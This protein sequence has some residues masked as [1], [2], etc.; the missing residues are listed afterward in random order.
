MN[1]D[2]VYVPK[3]RVITTP[4]AEEPRHQTTV[5]EPKPEH[6][7][8][9]GEPM[10]DPQKIEPVTPTESDNDDQ[11]VIDPYN[12]QANGGKRSFGR[13][14]EKLGD[15]FAGKDDERID[16]ERII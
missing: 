13:F 6:H 7:T 15:I 11:I 2:D 4:P 3:P 9:S 8:H 10:V 14:L 1:N 16:D 5:E 12:N